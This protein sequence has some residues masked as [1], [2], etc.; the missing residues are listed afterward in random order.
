[1]TR[2]FGIA[3]LW[4]GCSAAGA[5]QTYTET[6]FH[7]FGIFTG[8]ANPYGTLARDSA[9]NLFGTA[10][11]GG[12]ADLGVVFEYTAAGT[13]KVL[14]SFQGNTSDGSGPYAG[15][16]LDAAGNVYGTT[17]SGGSAGLGVVY[18]INTSGQ[19]SVLHSFTGGSDGSEP[20]AG[21]VID[22]AGNIY[23]TTISGGTANAG[24]VYKITT[25]GQESV[26]Y[27]FTGGSDGGT[28]YSLLVVDSSGNLYG[29]TLLGGPSNVG[30]IFKITPAGKESVVF[31]F[32]T[33]TCGGSPHGGVVI[34][35]EGNFYGATGS[36]VYKFSPSS[37]CTKLAGLTEKNGGEASWNSLAI[38]SAGNLY[39]TTMPPDPDNGPSPYGSVFKVTP[40][41]V[42][43]GL[44]TF[45][46]ASA[47]DTQPPASP[48]NGYPGVVLDSNGDVYVASPYGGVS[49]MVLKIGATG[50][51]TVLHSFTGAPGGTYPGTLLLTATGEIYGTTAEGGEWNLGTVFKIDSTGRQTVLYSFPGGDAGESPFLGSTRD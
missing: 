24:V 39:G 34:D 50:T 6:V 37:G 30:T 2:E 27:S 49:G 46:N 43:T 18:K 28:P 22:A 5:A 14:H 31:G 41:G 23:G 36:T 45:S 13:F 12:T 48:G 21:V 20:Y 47:A 25:A 51:S 11:T 16:S 44:Y 33:R 15:P 7:Q 29:T 4:I 19:E 26:L 40:S 9:G 42:L 17:Y 32:N 8:G 35:S 3:L 10:Y 1:M 38:D